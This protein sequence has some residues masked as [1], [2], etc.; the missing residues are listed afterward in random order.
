MPGTDC[1]EPN[2]HLVSPWYTVVLTA[3]PP[4]LARLRVS[5]S[6]LSFDKEYGV[7]RGIDDAVIAP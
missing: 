5:E 3:P 7:L 4:R 6:V 2:A 1:R